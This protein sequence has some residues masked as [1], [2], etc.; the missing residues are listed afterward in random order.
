M[1]VSYEKDIMCT[2]IVS[3]SN[4]VGAEGYI[5]DYAGNKTSNNTQAVRGVV[6][7]GRPANQATEVIYKGECMSYLTLGNT[8][9]TVGQ[10][11][12]ASAN[13]C[14]EVAGATTLVGAVAL[15]NC[16]NSNNTSLIRICKL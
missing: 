6:R 4:L 12:S 14:W 8:T 5:V 9:I 11:L 1:A 10:R 15:E 16:N 13:G 7:I 2:T 3:P